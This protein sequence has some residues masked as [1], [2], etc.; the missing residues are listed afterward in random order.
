MGFV[1]LVSSSLTDDYVWVHC[2]AHKSNN[3][4]HFV[5]HEVMIW[6]LQYTLY[7]DAYSKILSH[8]LHSVLNQQ[9]KNDDNHR[10]MLIIALYHFWVSNGIFSI[11]VKCKRASLCPQSF[12]EK[13]LIIKKPT[14][15]KKRNLRQ[16]HRGGI[17]ACNW[18]H[19]Y[20]AQQHDNK[21]IIIMSPIHIKVRDIWEPVNPRPCEK[22]MDPGACEH[23][24]C[25]HMFLVYW[26]RN[27]VIPLN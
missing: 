26:S 9:I 24:K 19:K 27:R 14:R 18:C 3:V 23:Y 4:Q 20:G 16:N 1:R 25:K 2:G 13:T 5:W 17:H 15:K 21:N 22:T 7:S 6:H 12:E 10:I 8:T 11:Q